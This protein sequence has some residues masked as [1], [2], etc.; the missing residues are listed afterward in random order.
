MRI[1]ELLDKRSIRIDGAPKSKNEA[2][3]QMVELMA[4]SGKI[5][6]LEAYRQEVYRR[7]EEG[8]TGDRK[9]TRLN[10]SHTDSSRMPSSA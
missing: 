8:T 2:L 6:D 4:K 3:D 7:E 10:S 9:S 1:T 5:N